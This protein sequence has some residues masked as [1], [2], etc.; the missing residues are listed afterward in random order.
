M[1]E[2]QTLMIMFF[3]T[4]KVDNPEKNNLFSGTDPS[5]QK[6]VLQLYMVHSLGRKTAHVVVL[7]NV[8]VTLL[9]R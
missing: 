5:L 8:V 9:L 6:G 4:L 2:I 7:K 1:T 3:V